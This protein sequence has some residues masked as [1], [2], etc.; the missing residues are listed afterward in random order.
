MFENTDPVV[1]GNTATDPNSAGMAVNETGN[2]LAAPI[3]IPV[4][5]ALPEKKKREEKTIKRQIHT[6]AMKYLTRLANKRYEADTT[7]DYVP[8]TEAEIKAECKKRWQEH[9][10]REKGQADISMYFN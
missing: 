8:P 4:P 10:D 9:V 3:V 7:K 1:P 5:S 6:N 2:P